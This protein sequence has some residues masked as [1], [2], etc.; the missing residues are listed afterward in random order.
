MKRKQEL[1][2]KLK[3][4]YAKEE[5]AIRQQVSLPSINPEQ[6]EKESKEEQKLRLQEK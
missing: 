6:K 2:S 3:A 5:V 4:R 1:V